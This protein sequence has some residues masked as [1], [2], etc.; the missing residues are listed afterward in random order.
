MKI[1]IILII[2]FSLFLSKNKK[3]HQVAILW[4]SFFFANRNIKVPDTIPYMDMYE[5]GTY[6]YGVEEAFLKLCEFSNN[7]GLSFT[8]FLFILT[9]VTLEIWYFCTNILFGDE[10]VGKMAVLLFSYYGIYYFGAVLRSS[11]GITLCYLGLTI[12]LTKGPRLVPLICYYILV[13]ISFLIQ[14]STFLFLLAP[15]ALIPIKSKYLYLITTCAFFLHTTTTILPIKSYLLSLSSMLGTTR[16]DY[17][18]DLDPTIGVGFFDI[19]LMLL[20]Y[21]A[22]YCKKEFEFLYRGKFYSFFL[23]LFIAALFI[24]SLVSTIPAGARLPMN[25]IYFI[26]VL[27]YFIIYKSLLFGSYKTFT[28]IGVVV[29]SLFMLFH[30]FPGFLKY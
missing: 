22:I 7:L 14:Q 11:I 23:N 21:L 29:F 25:W 9:F 27:L 20:A 15:L 24:L 30:T 8:L 16:F 12:L 1:I 26:F 10:A 6:Y 18:T 19:F 2:A 28:L 13:Y 17:Y 5:S 4:L 3:L